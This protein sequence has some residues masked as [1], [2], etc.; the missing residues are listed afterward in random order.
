MDTIAGRHMPEGAMDDNWT[1]QVALESVRDQVDR[2][3]G[4]LHSN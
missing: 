1:I 4:A 2:L 3:A